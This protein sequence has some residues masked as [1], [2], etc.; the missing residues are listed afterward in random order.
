MDRRRG[1]AHA[2]D[3]LRG[4][5]HLAAD[6]EAPG[7]TPRRLAREAAPHGGAHRRVA[8]RAGS[9]RRAPRVDSVAARDPRARAFGAERRPRTRVAG[10]GIGAARMTRSD[11]LRGV[12][13]RVAAAL[14]TASDV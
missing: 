2:R 1:D 10:G 11:E 7:R 8:D 9:T 5:P 12:A 6:V 4:Q 13:E 3:R 14:P